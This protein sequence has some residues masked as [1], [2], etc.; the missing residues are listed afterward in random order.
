MTK[1]LLTTQSKC[2]DKQKIQFLL[3]H[4]YFNGRRKFIAQA[5]MK[6]QLKLQNLRCCDLNWHS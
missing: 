1:K 5:Q 4:H 6:K 3:I 2:T